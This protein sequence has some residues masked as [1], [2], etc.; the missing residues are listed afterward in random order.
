MVYLGEDEPEA[1]RIPIPDRIY[2]DA[3][4][5]TARNSQ[6]RR[7]PQI[8]LY[9]PQ[10]CHAQNWSHRVRTNIIYTLHLFTLLVHFGPT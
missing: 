4:S 9:Q 1:L 3:G 7:L 2:S 10:Q 6:P 8:P 5:G